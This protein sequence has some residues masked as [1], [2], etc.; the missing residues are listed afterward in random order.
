[1]GKWRQREFDKKGNQ[2]VYRSKSNEHCGMEADM[3]DKST[4]RKRR[5]SGNNSVKDSGNSYVNVDVYID[6]DHKAKVR[7]DV[8][9]EEKEDQEQEQEKDKKKHKKHY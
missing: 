8:D 5:N 9:F 6:S 4:R 7:S 1:M 3:E 2:E